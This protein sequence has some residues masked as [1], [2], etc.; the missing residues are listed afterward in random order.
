MTTACAHPQK[1]QEPLVYARSHGEEG[2]IRTTFGWVPMCC[3]CGR[4]VG[5]TRMDYTP[6][7]KAIAK[8]FNGTSWAAML[9]SHPFPPFCFKRGGAGV[10]L[11]E[12]YKGELKVQAQ[13]PEEPP[14]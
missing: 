6:E 7:A 10:L 4:I 1:K 2:P 14:F 13:L 11:P 12:N 3:A 8:M 5:D 9:D